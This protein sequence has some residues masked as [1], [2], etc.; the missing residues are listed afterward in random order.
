MPELPA[1]PRGS[2]SQVGAALYE[3]FT[4][5]QAAGFTEAQAMYVTGKYAEAMIFR[6]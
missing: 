3:L 6:A 1:D 5:L 4:S 2:L